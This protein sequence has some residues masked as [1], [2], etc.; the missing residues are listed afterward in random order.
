MSENGSIA[1][2]VAASGV[3]V[4]G[5]GT[6]GVSGSATSPQGVEV[7]AEN[8]PG[9]RQGP[10]RPGGTI[11]AGSHGLFTI[12]LSRPSPTKRKWPGWSSTDEGSPLS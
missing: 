5:V 11:T 2:R 6:T 12:H 4:A 8:D 10:V 1:G 7:L 9:Q 3:G